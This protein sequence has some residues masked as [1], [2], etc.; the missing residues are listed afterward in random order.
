MAPVCM[1][2]TLHLLWSSC[3][4]IELATL[5]GL[6]SHLR[7]KN[8]ISYSY[9]TGSL[10]LGGKLKELWSTLHKQNEMQ[11]ISTLLSLRTEK[12]CGSQ[13]DI[14]NTTVT[15]ITECVTFK[16]V[17]LR[18]ESLFY[19]LTEHCKSALTL[20]KCARWL[21]IHQSSEWVAALRRKLPLPFNVIMV[22]LRS[23]YH[24]AKADCVS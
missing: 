11:I 5:L 9:F 22:Q 15:V 1:L 16:S 17:D 12:H 3:Q 7:D 23:A 14:S 6:S 19:T 18:F 24:L 20:T 21:S 13:G 8:A 4:P 10:R 2:L